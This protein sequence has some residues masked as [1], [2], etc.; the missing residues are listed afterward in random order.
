MNNKGLTRIELLS[1]LMLLLIICWVVSMFI[2][3]DDM[4]CYYTT[5][6]Y[7]CTFDRIG[8]DKE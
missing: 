7:I 1:V 6:G 3:R 4:K 8:E 2:Y 5:K